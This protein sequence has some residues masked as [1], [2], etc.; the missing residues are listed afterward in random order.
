MTIALFLI[1]V[2]LSGF[3]G[4]KVSRKIRGT[5]VG[6]IAPGIGAL[7]TGLGGGLAGCG[8]GHLVNR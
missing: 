7:A 6:I 1:I 2:A 3:V 5:A 4:F 8:L